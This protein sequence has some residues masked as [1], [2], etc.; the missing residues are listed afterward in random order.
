MTFYDTVARYYDAENADKTDDIALYRD[1]TEDYPGAILDVGCGTGRVVLPLARDG[2]TVHGI[3]NN[4]AML[5][6]AHKRI[7]MQPQAYPHLTLQQGDILK[8]ELPPTKYSMVLLS[9]NML[10]HFHEQPKQIALLERMREVIKMDG[11]LV[12][13]LPN[14]ADTFA[15]PDSD[16]ITLERTFIDP[17]TGHMV[18]QQA[19]SALDRTTQ[20]MRVHWIYDAI[21]GE[22]A[23]HR[24]VAPTLFRYYFPYEVQ[25]LLRLTG[26]G[27]DQILGDADGSPFE[28]GCPRMIVL[29]TPEP[30]AI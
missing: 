4:A 14:P 18:M 29:A 28:D 13:D 24:T 12:L 30:E 8:D 5:A 27:I 20:L 21:D 1:L 9:Y 6:R 11:V 22:G 25:L 19:V 3:D 16:A 2:H 10:M 7:A 17:E 15:T 26:F 23:V